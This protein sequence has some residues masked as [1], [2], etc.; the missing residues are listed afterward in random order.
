MSI[1]EEQLKKVAFAD[2]RDFDAISNTYTIK[3][4]VDPIFTVGKAYIIEV[5]DE[6][7]NNTSSVTAVN[8]NNCRAPQAKYYKVYISKSAGKMIFVDGLEYNL[9]TNSDLGRMWSGWLNTDEI[10]QIKE[11]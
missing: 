3:R 10:T 2:L 11:V 6:F 5:L 7:I 8:W 1:V 4:K 9:E